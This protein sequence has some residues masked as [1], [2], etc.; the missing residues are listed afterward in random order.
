MAFFFWEMVSSQIPLNDIM[1]IFPRAV[2]RV[3]DYVSNAKS[4][5]EWKRGGRQVQGG[6]RKG[7]D[8]FGSGPPD[9][10]STNAFTSARPR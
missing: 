10:A 7:M 5:R 4:L 9:Y 8:R 2:D 3:Q 1:H 6:N